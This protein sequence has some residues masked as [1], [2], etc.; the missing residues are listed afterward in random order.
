MPLAQRPKSPL[1]HVHP[2]AFA[3]PSVLRASVTAL[4]VTTIA[5]LFPGATPA[6]A[7]DESSVFGHHERKGATLIGIFYDLKQTQQREPIPDFA[8]RYVIEIDAFLSSGFDEAL[9]NRFFRAALPLYTTQF[10]MPRMNADAA[11]K[12]FGV[13]GLVKPKYWVIHYKGQIAP[14]VD[15]TY[16]FVGNFDDLLIVAIN[17]K[18]VLD[19]SRPDTRMKNLAWKEAADKGPTVAANTLA[20]YGDWVDLK[21]DQPVDIDILIGERPGGFFHGV[22]LYEKKGESYGVNAKGQAVLPLF[23]LAPNPGKDATFT[24]DRPVW[25]CIE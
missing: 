6:A 3:R 9:F 14:P 24:T 25:K 8:R 19:G 7:Q 4:A 12:A 5:V 20:K 10:S 1:S 21:A 22:L 18:V 15:G 16:R 17:R 13:E 2:P 23:Q 11:P